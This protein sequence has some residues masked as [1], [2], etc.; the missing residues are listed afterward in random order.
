MQRYEVVSNDPFDMEPRPDG[1]WVYFADAAAAQCEM[2]WVD[3]PPTAD[4]YYWLQRDDNEPIIV[5]VWNAACGVV[6]CGAM[7]AFTGSDCDRDVL[8]LTSE[9]RCRWFGPL[10]APPATASASSATPPAR[11]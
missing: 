3:E 8:E 2:R 1:A 11:P 7:V 9:A 6:D 10:K 5:K 4:G